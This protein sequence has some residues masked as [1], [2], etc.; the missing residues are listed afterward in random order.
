MINNYSCNRFEVLSDEIEGLFAKN[1]N[2]EGNK[3]SLLLLIFDFIVTVDYFYLF[4]F[5]FL[6]Y[7]LINKFLYKYK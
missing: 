4:S 3:L 5:Y 2:L 7:L 1:L 6:L